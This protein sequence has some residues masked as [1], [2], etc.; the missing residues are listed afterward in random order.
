MGDMILDIENK[1]KWK[2][3]SLEKWLGLRAVAENIT[4][5]VMKNKEKHTPLWAPNAMF[6]STEGELR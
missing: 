4:K 3:N 6:R 5:K 2:G 1:M